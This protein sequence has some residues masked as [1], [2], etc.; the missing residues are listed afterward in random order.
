MRTAVY[1]QD[2]AVL[3]VYGSAGTVKFD[4]KPKVQVLVEDASVFS[5]AE[6]LAARQLVSVIWH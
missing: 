4:G 6:I 3:A 5:Q 2:L 1:W